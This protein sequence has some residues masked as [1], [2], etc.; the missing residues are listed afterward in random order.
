MVC[1]PMRRM[2]IASNAQPWTVRCGIAANS[3]SRAAMIRM[4]CGT[5]YCAIPFQSAAKRIHLFSCATLLR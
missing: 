2:S 5:S 3:S 1:V 4:A